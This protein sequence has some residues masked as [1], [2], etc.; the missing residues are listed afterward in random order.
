MKKKNNNDNNNDNSNDNDSRNDDDENVERSHKLYII[1]FFETLST[2]NVMFVQIIFWTLNNACSQHS[3]Q[4]KSAFISYIV[5]NKLISINDL[6]KSVYIIRQ[7]IV[8]MICRVSNK[9][10]NISFFDAFYVS[11][12]FLNL[13]SFD[14]LNEIRCFMS[15]KLSLFGLR[16]KT[17]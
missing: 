1:M 15:Y 16:I 9:R 17:S 5:F 12:C 4:K 11:K 10:V 14:Q 3:I 8:R 13:I 7:R 6:A 2:M